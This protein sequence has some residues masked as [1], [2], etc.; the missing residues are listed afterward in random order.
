MTVLVSSSSTQGRH[1]LLQAGNIIHVPAEDYGKREVSYHC[2]FLMVGAH[3]QEC[4]GAENAWFC[5]AFGGLFSACVQVSPGG[6]VSVASTGLG[7]H[8]AVPSCFGVQ[9]LSHHRVNVNT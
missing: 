5:C 2:S 1:A 8:P 4:L 3:S 7:G 9:M 6:P